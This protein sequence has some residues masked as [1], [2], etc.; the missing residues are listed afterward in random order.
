MQKTP[1][2]E[3]RRG[4]ARLKRAIEKARREVR[5]LRGALAQVEAD[6]FPGDDYAEMDRHL[7][8]ADEIAK[9][10]SARQQ[11]KVLRAGGIAPGGLRRRGGSALR[12]T[13]G[14]GE[15]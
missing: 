4:L 14:G 8:A 6:G 15:P 5:G 10:E 3:A 11:A 13:R 2:A 9:R 7:A 1:E 12:A